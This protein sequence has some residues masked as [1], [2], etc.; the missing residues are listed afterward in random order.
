MR[1]RRVTLI[2]TF[3]VA[4]FLPAMVLAAPFTTTY[5]FTGSPGDQASEPVDAN[6]VGA[7]FSAIT[8]GS[9]IGPEMG[10]NSI[11]SFGWTT[12]AAIDPND[13]Y[14]FTITPDANIAMDLTNLTFTYRRSATGPTMLEIRSSLDG[15]A[16]AF[17]GVDNLNDTAN[18]R[19]G[20]GLSGF[21]NLESAITF[22]IYGF[23]AS[24]GAGTF[25]LGLSGASTLVN[26]LQVSGQLDPIP[27]PATLL[28]IGAGLTALAR[29]RRRIAGPACL[30]V[31]LSLPTAAFAAP[32][33][34]TYTFTGSPGNQASEPVDANPVGALFSAITRG[35][36]V[37]ASAG[38]DSINSSGWTTGAA[39]DVNDYY[40]FTITPS[41]NFALDVT[42]LAFTF[43]RSATGPRSFEVRNSLDGFADAFWNIEL[44]DSAQNF[45]V[46]SSNPFGYNGSLDLTTPVTFRIYGF[47]AE[48]EG[49][50]FRLGIA[51]GEVNDD[52][53]ANLEVGGQLD[54]VPE[55]ATLLLIG[56]GLT[57]MRL[58][59]RRQ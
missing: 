16:A 8:R 43:R 36:G 12:G 39:I 10:D 9:G 49:G 11:N 3:V 33:T 27:E 31:A 22:R 48:A 59:R 46:T 1:Q 17:A 50:T 13:Y 58:R 20:F 42:E 25:R 52:L 40:E 28:L 6:P 26:N 21:T 29:R 5:T 15:F 32:F 41:A 37:V 18:H 54:P 34:A 51:N 56:A 4:V 24:S 45:R 55:P 19:T 47:R 2:C 14:E 35:P 23:A 30:L 7:L 53:P 38:I 44:G 57:A